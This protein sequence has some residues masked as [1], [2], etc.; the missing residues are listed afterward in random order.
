M[1][2]YV[3]II[4]LVIPC[5]LEGNH[6]G[7]ESVFVGASWILDEDKNQNDTNPGRLAKRP[8]HTNPDRVKS[9]SLWHESNRIAPRQRSISG[10]EQ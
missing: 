3:L 5:L 9:R 1:L 10:Y 6:P 2:L 7:I 8:N 4:I